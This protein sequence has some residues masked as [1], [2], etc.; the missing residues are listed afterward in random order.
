[1]HVDTNAKPTMKQSIL[2]IKDNITNKLPPEFT[3]A[4]AI[5][6]FNEYYKAPTKALETWVHNGLLVR[7]K[8][9]LFVLKDNFQPIA[10]VNAIGGAAYGSFE[11][12]LAYY[13]LIPERTPNIIAVIDGRSCART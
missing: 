9:G 6:L 12:A 4:E 13:G 3:A 5:D 2:N 8:K 1:M 11:T 7:L 10:A